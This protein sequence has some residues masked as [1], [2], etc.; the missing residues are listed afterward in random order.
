MRRKKLDLAKLPFQGRLPLMSIMLRFSTFVFLSCLLQM[1]LLPQSS[2]SF[3]TAQAAVVRVSLTADV[4]AM[5][6][7]SPVSKSVRRNAS[8]QEGRMG[9]L[10]MMIFIINMMI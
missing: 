5:A 6:T 7:T 10:F 3:S 9:L 4:E 2:G 8:A 1:L